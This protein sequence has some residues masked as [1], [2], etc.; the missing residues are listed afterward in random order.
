MD[1]LNLGLALLIF[2]GALALSSLLVWLS[3]AFAHRFDFLDRPDGARK[4]QS[5][6]IP[7]LGGVAVAVTFT[8]SSLLVL[9]R[10]EYPVVLKEAV[11]ML[12]PAIAAA[13]IGY[14]DDK[15]GLSPSLRLALQACVGAAIALTLRDTVSISNFSLVNVIVTILWVMALINGV[16]LLD[17]S[18][19]LAGATVLICA[20]TSAAVGFISGQILISA[21]GI[22]L[23]GTAAGFLVHNWNPARVYMGD[24]GAYFF[25]T[26]LAAI[27]RGEIIASAIHDP[28]TGE[29]AYALRGEGA[30]IN[31]GFFVLEPRV[32]DYIEGDHTL[33]EH[34]PLQRLAAEDQLRASRHQGFWQPMDTL[35]EKNYLEELWASGKAPWKTWA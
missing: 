32:L 35:R 5:H 18:D 19:G 17:N 13:T 28:F 12:V 20:L 10:S 33:W 26:M 16:N 1:S 6:A 4:F 27:R 29:T 30:W 3:I 11:G 22:A 15:R 8:A 14:A 21:L 7:K 24:S 9:S 34:E 2:I 23:S 31:G 25:G